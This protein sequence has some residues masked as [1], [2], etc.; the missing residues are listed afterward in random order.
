M[1]TMDKD[2]QLKMSSDDSNGFEIYRSVSN[3]MKSDFGTL[4]ETPNLFYLD[5]EEQ[6]FKDCDSI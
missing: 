5:L 2:R 6:K 1:R 4:N 3:V